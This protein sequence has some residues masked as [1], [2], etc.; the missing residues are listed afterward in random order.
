MLASPLRYHTPTCW[1]EAVLADFD[2]FLLDHAT[3][4]KKA[5]GMAISMLSHYPDR[6]ALVTAMADLAIEELTHYREVLKWIH[7]RGLT[8]AP[9]Q[10]DP[11]V[12]AFRNSIRHGRE[13]YLMDRLLTASI[14]EARGAERFALVA[15]ALETGPLKKFYQS[16]ARSEERHFELFLTL[17]GQY[18]DADAIARRW[19]EL[20]DIEADLVARLPIRAALH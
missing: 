12:V 13:V 16:I 10:K 3:A 17:A 6:T 1:T 20:L 9:D 8:I 15:E 14:I 19:D 18:L 11:Y 2:S 4:E 5:S 7:Q